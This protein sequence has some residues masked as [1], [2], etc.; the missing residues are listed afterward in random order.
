MVESGHSKLYLFTIML[1]FCET[2]IYI[3]AVFVVVSSV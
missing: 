3:S 2:V 1:P